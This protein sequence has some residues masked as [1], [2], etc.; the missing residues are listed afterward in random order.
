MVVRTVSKVGVRA[1]HGVANTGRWAFSVWNES[2]GNLRVGFG[3]REWLVTQKVHAGPR[4]RLRL[5]LC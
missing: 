5:V 1:T 3:A 4:I 2:G